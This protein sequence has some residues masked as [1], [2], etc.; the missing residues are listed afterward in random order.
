MLTFGSVCSGIEAASVAFN[1]LNWTPTWFSEIDKFP[2]ALLQHHYPS[3]ENVGD[4]RCI[5][6]RLNSKTLQAPDLLC[7]GTPCQSFSVAGEQRSLE[8]SRGELTLEFCNI[9]DTIDEQR[10]AERK[11]PC[12]LLW[13]NVPGVL[14]TKDN[15]FGCFLGKLA[16]ANAPLSPGAGR[17]PSAGYV[18]GPKRKVAWRVLDAQYFG[19]PQRRRRI[20][21]IASAREGFDPSKVL[22]ECQ[23]MLWDTNQST[24]EREGT[25]EKIRARSCADCSL[26]YRE[27]GFGQYTE[28]NVAGTL[29]ASG[30]TVGSGGETLVIYESHAADA[31]YNET[32]V[33][34]TLLA[35]C[36]TGGGNVPLVVEDTVF[37]VRKLTPV[38]CER[39]QGFP[40][41]YTKVPYNGKPST[42][43]VRYK[44][45]GNSWAVPV[46][47][48]LAKR[49]QTNLTL[50]Q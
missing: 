5:V 17:W 25:A 13:E 27:S 37:K 23:S 44:A 35:S 50:C 29:R 48:W 30:G 20:F 21:V 46:I 1:D 43:T 10:K 12:V 7:G 31:R 6:A 41:N 24:K 18:V 14:S 15:A 9:A 2:R 34:P 4:M 19:V 33:C 47:K 22:F 26:G 40:D 38:E 42:D 11:E 49:I 28:C 36:G 3:I 45:L 16:G 8:D 39:L 32:P